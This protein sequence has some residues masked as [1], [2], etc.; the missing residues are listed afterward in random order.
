MPNDEPQRLTRSDERWLLG[1]EYARLSRGPRQKM[2]KRSSRWL[3]AKKRLPDPAAHRIANAHVMATFYAVISAQL[4]TEGWRDYAREFIKQPQWWYDAAC[5]LLAQAY[6]EQ[7]VARC[8]LCRVEDWAWLLA[9]V[10]R[11]PKGK[12]FDPEGNVKAAESQQE[13]P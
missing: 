5:L 10:P 8:R 4:E 9:A 11:L 12:E 7:H 1:A 6:A 3:D 13:G 2:V